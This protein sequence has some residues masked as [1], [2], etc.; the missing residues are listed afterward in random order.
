MGQAVELK[1]SRPL[2]EDSLFKLAVSLMRI[3]RSVMLQQIGISIG[4]K[5]DRLYLDLRPI[6]NESSL[7]FEVW[8]SGN[9][10]LYTRLKVYQD[11]IVLGERIYLVI[12][13][14]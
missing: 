2:S 6:Q 7:V 10:E 1:P 12:M 9:D 11:L 4:C 14:L 5:A 3:G 8:S 13:F